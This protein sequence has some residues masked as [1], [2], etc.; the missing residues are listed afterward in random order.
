MPPAR[1]LL[2]SLAL[3]CAGGLPTSAGAAPPPA[4]S[5]P[6][7]LPP[8]AL[9][10]PL[11]ESAASSAE[12]RQRLDNPAGLRLAGRILDPSLLRDFYAGRNYQPAWTGSAA[13]AADRLL[14]DIHAAAYAQG[15]PPQSYAVPPTAS[16]VDHD[17]LVSDA[18]ARFG[19]DLATGRVAPIQAY[20]GLGTPTR[21]SFDATAFL[22]RAS[23]TPSLARLAADIEPTDPAYPRLIAALARYRAIVAAGGWPSIPDGPTI[24]PGQAD[25]R[26][27]LV[28]R[29]LIASG[30]LEAVHGRARGA[31]GDVLDHRTVTALR[32][33]QERHGLDVDGCIGKQ[34]LAEL[35]V[36]ARDRLR[37]IE[38]NLERWRSVPRLLEATRVMVNLPAETLSL[39][40]DGKP[41]LAMRVV[42]GDPK[43]PT[44]PMATSMTAVI[45]NPTWTIPPSIATKEILPKLQRDPNYLAANN[46]RILGAFP[47]NSPQAAGLGIDWKSYHGPFP[48]RLRQNSGDDNALGQLKFYLKD[49]DAIYLHDTPQRTFFRRA[50]RALSH[51]CVRVEKPVDLAEQL[52]GTAWSGKVSGAIAARVTRTLRL[53]QPVPVYLMYWTAWADSDGVV[54]FRDDLYGHDG[55]LLDALDRT[56]SRMAGR[57]SAD[58]AGAPL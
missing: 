50:N 19:R 47:E 22:V 21:P 12:L 16:I 39:V 36:G 32:R 45:V 9:S 43:H 46:I 44:P 26:L 7:A 3:A 17:L 23:E 20:G 11:P 27:P 2:L 35:N 33:F 8:A 57:A 58:R 24:R 41:V 31:A 51:G 30:D 48:Y 54:H 13:V 38:A 49:L 15:L 37:Q 42:V 18:L 52:L 55:R 1:P 40:E 6:T 56:A 29:R 10:L 53:A 25:P 5:P 4:A 28:R 14:A 34:T